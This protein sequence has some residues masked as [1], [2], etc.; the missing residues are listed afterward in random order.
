VI[1]GSL[2]IIAGNLMLTF[3]QT[4]LFFLGLLV[5]AIG[6]GLLKP[7][8]S[9]MVAALYPEGGARRDAGFSA[10]YMGINLG[11]LI[12]PILVGWFATWLGYKWGFVLRRS[13]WPSGSPSSFGRVITWA[14]PGWRP[15]VTAA[16]GRPSSC[17]RCS[18]PRWRRRP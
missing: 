1:G 7:N 8:C 18:S 16:P 11:A 13:A 17:S 10:F 9:A 2:F 4:Q 5:I 12:G 3:G 14:E 15:R 6:I